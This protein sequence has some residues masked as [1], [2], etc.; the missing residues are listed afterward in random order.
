MRSTL[1][2]ALQNRGNRERFPLDAVQPRRVYRG[3]LD[4]L[5]VEHVGAPNT[6]PQPPLKR[7]PR[8]QLRHR[9][10]SHLASALGRR[11]VVRKLLNEQQRRSTSSAYLLQVVHAGQEPR[12]RE[13]A[14]LQDVQDRKASRTH[15]ECPAWAAQTIWRS[16]RSTMR[17]TSRQVVDGGLRSLCR[18]AMRQMRLIRGEL[19]RT[20]VAAAHMTS[21]AKVA[22]IRPFFE[23]CH[24]PGRGYSA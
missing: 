8:P 16:L 24:G 9:K 14:P 15:R 7:Q 23:C 22:K 5:S 6:R 10:R 11:P 1:K 17:R 21:T 18:V 13:A 4:M 3:V 12:R 20:K 19:G 2:N